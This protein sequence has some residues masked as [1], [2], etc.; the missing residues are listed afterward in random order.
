MPIPFLP[1]YE[2]SRPEM[3]LLLLA[4]PLLFLLR[5]QAGRAPAVVFSSLPFLKGASKPVRSRFGLPTAALLTMLALAAGILALA[6]PQET[7]SKD[8]FTA[9]G[10]E[11][12]LAIDV[13]ISMS[14]KDF[15][16]DRRVIDRLQA[17]KYVISE[18]VGGRP[19]DR[20]GLV[21]FAGQPVALGP[22]TLDHDWLL[23]TIDRE[24]H[25]KQPITSGTAIGR[26]IS[27]C[28]DRLA[29]RESATKAKSQVVVLLT[30]GDQ[31]VPGLTPQ[32]AADFA[33]TMGIKVY[34]IAIGTPGVHKVP[35]AN[36]QRMEQS[37]DIE[38]LRDIA[39]ITGGTAYLANDTETL[40]AI[41]ADIDQLEKSE[42]DKRTTIETRELF[43]W[44]AAAALIFFLAGLAYEHSSLNYGP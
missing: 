8:V 25:F 18:F 32:A 22:L 14:I 34:P 36:N 17:A 23:E 16:L 20:I 3:L 31:N 29:N 40:R 35:L 4:I 7:D 2:F 39:R 5:G 41:F 11:I 12:Y 15:S 13:S 33:A 37:F 30:D 28:S 9:S 27:A 42:I 19:S 21:I 6:R 43:Q 44:F 24:I 10:V 38:T 1:D 26:A